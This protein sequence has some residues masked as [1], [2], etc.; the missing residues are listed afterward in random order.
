MISLAKSGTA[1]GAVGCRIKTLL[2]CYG[3]L[4][5]E[6]QLY[7]S[8]EGA[9]LCRF[10][11]SIIMSGGCNSGELFEFAAMLG[12]DRIEWEGGEL[13]SPEDWQA[14]SLPILFKDCVGKAKTCFAELSRCF[15]IIAQSDDDF[16]A[17]MQYLYWLSD[18]T[19]RLNR[20]RAKGYL[21]ENAGAALV[22][23]ADEG[24][25]Y[26]SSVAVL[27]QNRGTG[28]GSRLLQ[29]VLADD[30]LCS[31]RLYTVAQSQSLTEF[32]QKN[33]FEP[34]PKRLAVFKRSI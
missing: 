25:A 15:E 22:T 17:Q 9:L 6:P 26:L 13:A 1:A 3:G 12:V 8:D 20:G 11:G 30:F 23:A 32:Y 16:S 27:P 29:T 34:Y 4:K 21:C 5:D 28:L 19:R 14:E 7:K 2:D 10:G 24:E 33:G 31:K 18:M